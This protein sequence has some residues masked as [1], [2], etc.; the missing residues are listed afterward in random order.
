MEIKLVSVV[1][2]SLG[3]TFFQFPPLKAREV[4]TLLEEQKAISLGKYSKVLLE[5][6][7]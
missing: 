3:K 1:I 6:P 5:I 2:V 4:T 7:L